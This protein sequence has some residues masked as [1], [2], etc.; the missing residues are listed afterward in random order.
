MVLFLCVRW[1]RIAYSVQGKTVTLYVDCE[2][3]ETLD[4]LRGDAA[5][6]STEGVTVFGTRL[7]DEEVFEV[8][9]HLE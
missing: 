9:A 2:K 8:G 5:V 1:H 3:V 6:L 4:L 7:M